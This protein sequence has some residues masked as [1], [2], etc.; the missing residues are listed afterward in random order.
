[1]YKADRSFYHHRVLSQ[2][3][4]LVQHEVIKKCWEEDIYKATA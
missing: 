1:M 4:T 2:N 3:T